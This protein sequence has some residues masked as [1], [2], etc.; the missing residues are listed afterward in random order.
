MPS[1]LIPR[2]IPVRVK[3]RD[4]ITNQELGSDAGYDNARGDAGAIRSSVSLTAYQPL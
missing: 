2:W 1:D 3:K 4:K